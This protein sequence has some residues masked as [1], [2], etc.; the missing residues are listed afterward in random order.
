[1]ISIKLTNND[2]REVSV[3]EGSTLL[4]IFRE[5]VGVLEGKGLIEPMLALVNNR[6]RGLGTKVFEPCQVEY[7]GYGRSSGARTYLRTLV[8]LMTH[9]A[10]ELGIGNLKM[11]HAIALGY[12][13]ILSGERHD[14]PEILSLLS[15]RVRELIAAN[16]SITQHKVAH[17][18]AIKL[19][20]ERGEVETAELI[21]TEARCYVT[22]TQLNGVEDFIFGPV[23]PQTSMVGDFAIEPYEAGFLLRI[24][25]PSQPKLLYPRIEQPK[26]FSVFNEHLKL[27]HLIGV[28]DV[29]PLNCSIRAGEVSNLIT[30]SEAMQEKTIARMAAEI[31]QRHR[32]EGLSI[33]LLSGPSSS[34]KTTTGKRL[35]TQL[36][37]NLLRPHLIS[38]D[39]FYVNRVDTPLNEAGNYDYESLYAL[40]IPH[41]NATLESLLQGKTTQMP[42][43][44][45][46][47]GERV[48]RPDDQLTL[49]PNDVLIMEGIHALNPE[50]FPNFARERLYKIYVSALTTISLDNHN[51]IS[52][53]DNR[54]LRRIVRD[55][56]Y[57]G[58]TAEESIARWKDVREGEEKWIFPY[59]EEADA[60][61]NS[62]MLYEIS[63][64][65]P[66]AD[67]ALLAVPEISPAYPTARRLLR[68]LS[69]FEPIELEQTPT[70][71]LI[72]EFLGGS[73][74]KY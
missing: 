52:T 11:E 5:N 34:G 74:F 69:L 13:G 67:R 40:D 28:D 38:L 50:L 26:L 47:L 71:S 70:T 48:I 2:D 35:Q 25:D 1:M 49:G 51:W 27:I 24:P 20:V 44:D 9:A 12:Y 53:S 7:I 16:L 23:L 45:F 60:M 72:R 32:E 68:L 55:I 4:E 63:A 29:A 66:Q 41:L 54:L 33:V 31:T 43:Y 30:I 19:F 57:R 17:D 62:A 39:D 46:K 15:E 8:L 3:R 58:V 64:L 10:R 21:C 61:F 65:R 14:E 42:Y 18:D 59:Q 22:L 36:I 56:K 6:E 73:T 37:T